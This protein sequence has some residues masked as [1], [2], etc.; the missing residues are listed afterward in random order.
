MPGKN[1]QASIPKVLCLLKSWIHQEG[2]QKSVLVNT[3]TPHM[4][5]H[6]DILRKGKNS[7]DIRRF[8]SPKRGAVYLNKNKKFVKKNIVRN[9]MY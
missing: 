3:A 4:G 7:N 5:V 8:S 9:N 1:S 6:G 2:K